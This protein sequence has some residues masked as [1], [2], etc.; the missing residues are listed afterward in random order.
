MATNY[1][2]L[3]GDNIS[4]RSPRKLLKLN[5]ISSAQRPETKM[6][7]AIKNEQLILNTKSNGRESLPDESLQFFRE[8]ALR[9]NW[10]P[11]INAAVD[12][13]ASRKTEK[14]ILTP[15]LSFSLTLFLLLSLSLSHSAH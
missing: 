14:Y 12:A 3:W 8:A 10:V 15:N 6:R 4:V 13:E 2:T 9:P 1:G 11:I 7:P 5:L